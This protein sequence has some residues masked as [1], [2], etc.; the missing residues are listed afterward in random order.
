[1]VPSA[2]MAIVYRF[3]ELIINS[4]PLKDEHNNTIKE[5]SI[6]GTGFDS[7]GFLENGADAVL[8][9]MVSTDIPNFKSG[10]DESFRSA[11][12]YRGAPLDLVV[13]SI[14]HEREQGLPTFN[15]VSISTSPPH[16]RLML[17]DYAVLASL[18]RDET[19][20]FCQGQDP[21]NFRGVH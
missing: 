9:G 15:D 14:V 17:T 20:T 19:G 7:R 21:G 2:E 4:F 6:F 18:R 10:V 13:W 12:K 8:R 16:H 11:G 1:M 5:M 3:H